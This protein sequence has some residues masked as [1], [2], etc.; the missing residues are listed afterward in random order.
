[1]GWPGLWRSQVWLDR[2][3]DRT[4]RFLSGII[5]G[6]L[7]TIGS[8]YVFDVSRKNEGPV[9]A[10]ERRMVNWDVVQAEIKALSGAIQDGWTRLAGHK[11]G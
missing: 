8:A 6:A 9:G 11:D 4:M 3:E 2:R 1:M 7:L 10:T 5:V